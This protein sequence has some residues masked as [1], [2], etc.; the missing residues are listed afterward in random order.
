MT[1]AA[2]QQIALGIVGA[3]TMGRGIA[4]VAASGGIQVFLTDAKP[5]AVSDAHDFVSKMLHRAAEKGNISKQDA[6]A[7]ISRI[8]Q[9]TSIEDLS[10]C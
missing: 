1:S 2:S 4:Q 10:K 9:V 5:G 3:G 8:H 6:E 7:A